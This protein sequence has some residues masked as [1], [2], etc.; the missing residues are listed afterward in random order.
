MRT[1][2]QE[3]LPLGAASPDDE[4]RL[5]AHHRQIGRRGLAEARAA[6]A[7]AAQRAAEREAGAAGARHAA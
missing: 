5:D 4:W 2:R 6:L 7:A 1:P 3:Q